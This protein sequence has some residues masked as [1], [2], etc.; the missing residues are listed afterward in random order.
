MSSL[1]MDDE[2]WE[3]VKVSLPL[4]SRHTKLLELA[5]AQS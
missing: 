1:E 5:N 4:I 3:E 2:D